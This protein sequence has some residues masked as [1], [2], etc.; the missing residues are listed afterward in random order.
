MRYRFARH[1]VPGFTGELL[2]ALNGMRAAAYQMCAASS[3]RAAVFHPDRQPLIVAFVIQVDGQIDPVARGRD[4]EFA[5]VADIL[6][7]VAQEHLHHVAVPKLV[8]RAAALRGQE[9]IQS[10]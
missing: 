5:V 3:M 9:Q 10:W 6:P 2:M 8:A 4:L 7:I 1:F